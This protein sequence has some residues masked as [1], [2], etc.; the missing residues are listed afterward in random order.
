MLRPFSV[1]FRGSLCR[2]LWIG[3]G[4][5]A[6]FIATLAAGYAML[7][8]TGE[9]AGSVGLDFIAFYTAGTFVDQ[10]N[11]RQLYDLHA[12]GAFQHQL[13]HHLGADLGQAIGPWWNPP[14]YAW[15]F[16]PL[17]K[18]SYPAALRVW[19]AVNLLCVAGA[20]AILVRWLRA[21]GGDVGPA[22]WALIPVLVILSTPFLQSMTH[23]QSTGMSLLILTLAVGAWRKERA[24]VAGLVLGLL[25]YKPQLCAAVAGVMALSLGSR[26]L[27]GL[28]TTVTSLTLVNV[29]T[30]PGTIGD[31]LE[32]LPQNLHFVLYEV[33]Y[34]WDRHVTFKA[35][36]R[37]LLNGYAVGEP[38]GTLTLITGGCV[39]ALGAAL[40]FAA[41]ETRKRIVGKPVKGRRVLISPADGRRMD[42][43]I[44]ATIVAAPLLMPFYFDYDQ[45]LLA[46]PAVLLAV[47]ILQRPGAGRP[48]LLIGLWCAWYAWLML[49]PDIAAATR[50]NGAVV[51]LAALSAT[52]VTRAWRQSKEA[53]LPASAA[54][55]PPRAMAA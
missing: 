42:R 4:G 9:R 12:V 31:Y 8:K 20:V 44:A 39:V 35:F 2:R 52:L 26:A 30:L 16:V 18:L 38:S 45:L 34:L 17:A 21:A 43:L 50:V 49:N 19:L 33:P 6:L 5:V 24:F 11:S 29:L 51:L 27:L 53:A 25:A 22:K 47:E 3:A 28:A 48:G 7:P 14:F 41:M 37:L 23:G 36:W 15:L 32:Q 13:A 54:R 46:I 40:C 55:I 10:G 1:I